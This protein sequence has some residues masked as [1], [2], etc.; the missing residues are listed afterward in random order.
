MDNGD[1]VPASLLRRCRP[2]RERAAQA[3]TRCASSRLSSRLYRRP[4]AEKEME[5][6]VPLSDPAVAVRFGF[7]RRG[8]LYQ[9]PS[10][11]QPLSVTFR[12]SS[13]FGK[14]DSNLLHFT[15]SLALNH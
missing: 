6:D 14:T 4:G 15:P 5:V 10:R 7:C 3:E 12:C 13:G 9:T 11:T 2:G 1:G 8:E